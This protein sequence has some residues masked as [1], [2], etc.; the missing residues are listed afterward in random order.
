MKLVVEDHS[1]RLTLNVLSP[2]VQGDGTQISPTAK[3]PDSY[4]M[5]WKKPDHRPLQ[6]KVTTWRL[7]PKSPLSV[8]KLPH[9]KVPITK[10][11][12][13]PIP[14]VLLPPRQKQ[15][16]L[17]LKSP[18][19]KARQPNPYV[20]SGSSPLD[21][22]SPNS[23]LSDS[24]DD[25]S[26]PSNNSE[27]LIISD[28]SDSSLSGRSSSSGS[29]D[30][31]S[32]MSDLFQRTELILHFDSQSRLVVCVGCSHPE[33]VFTRT[34]RQHLR[35]FHGAN[36]ARHFQSAQRFFDAHP[37]RTETFPSNLLSP[38]PVLTINR[39]VKCDGCSRCWLQ[40]EERPCSCNSNTRLIG[41]Q[42][43]TVDGP[44]LEVLTWFIGAA[45]ASQESFPL[46][47][48]EP[49]TGSVDS[50]YG[51]EQIDLPYSDL[52]KLIDPADLALAEA[53]LIY[54]TSWLQY[55]AVQT[56]GRLGF[57]DDI[58]INLNGLTRDGTLELAMLHIMRT[59]RSNLSYLLSGRLRQALDRMVTALDTPLPSRRR[60]DE[61]D[62]SFLDAADTAVL[63]AIYCLLSQ[64]LGGQFTECPFISVIAKWSTSGPEWF[65]DE[66]TYRRVLLFLKTRLL[67]M[68]FRKACVEAP[69]DPRGWIAE[70]AELFD[71]RGNQALGKMIHVEHVMEMSDDTLSSSSS[72]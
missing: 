13:L 64:G 54:L 14:L 65:T 62:W 7:K 29:L 47:F 20:A 10:R 68:L 24:S 32:P 1:P 5:K 2:I 58:D 12:R 40:N 36:A 72:V 61:D 27:V 63:D 70:S 57:P 9:A 66:Q 67:T 51:R 46:M 45:T 34:M 69:E 53:H 30:S 28:T 38:L 4:N 41:T 18:N 60:Y 59:Y 49:D 26:N 19:C 23:D 8:L 56:I 22:V 37:R 43:C 39:K 35:R 17:A 21:F 25:E 31:D 52:V 55:A 16:P 50:I 44:E 15:L 48:T 3:L 6:K 42:R 71:P 11:P 33:V